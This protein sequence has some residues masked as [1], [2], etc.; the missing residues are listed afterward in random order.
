MA[1]V[2]TKAIPPHNLGHPA[3]KAWFL[4]HVRHELMS[5]FWNK[6]IGSSIC[7]TLF[8]GFSFSSQPNR[9]HLYMCPVDAHLSCPLWHGQALEG[10][11]FDANV[12][13]GWIDWHQCWTIIIEELLSDSKSY[14]LRYK[15]LWCRWSDRLCKDLL[16]STRFILLISCFKKN[17]SASPFCVMTEI[18]GFHS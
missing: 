6:W 7:S 1:S 17:L 11:E 9:F 5:K 10:F 12:G 4:S 18:V 8:T 13:F 14:L 15:C 3:R 16:C 2:G